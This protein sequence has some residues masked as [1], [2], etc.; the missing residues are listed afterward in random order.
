MADFSREAQLPTSLPLEI[1]SAAAGVNPSGG[2]ANP[3]VLIGEIVD[4]PAGG[5]PQ[6]ISPRRERIDAALEMGKE[7]LV[8]TAA[9]AGFLALGATCAVSSMYSV[10]N[11]AQAAF[12]G[13]GGNPT[14]E[15]FPQWTQG[16]IGEALLT[17]NT[18]WEA[19]GKM[20]L[21]W[22]AGRISWGFLTGE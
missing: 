4:M 6:E 7:A 16:P 5:W 21:G 1:T 20:A 19:L 2:Q 18:M 8:T 17:A 15:G 22:I 13:V 11:A 9:G 10:Y 14:L 12:I 3:D